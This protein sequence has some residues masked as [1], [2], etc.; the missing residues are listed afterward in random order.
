[1][2][3]GIATCD[4]ALIDLE[5]VKRNTKFEELKNITKEYVSYSRLAFKSYLDYSY[6]KNPSDIALGNKYTTL[7]NQ[8][9][10]N[11]SS[12]LLQLLKQNGYAYEDNGN[13]QVRYYI[14]P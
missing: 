14:R 8:T 11:F 13:G 9:S 12:T 7:I 1:M 5:G 3:N 4:Q 10:A 2:L 6:S